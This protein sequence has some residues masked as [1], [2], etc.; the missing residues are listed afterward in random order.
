MSGHSRDHFGR[1]KD[2]GYS[3]EEMAGKPVDL[4]HHRHLVVYNPFAVFAAVVLL[5]GFMAIV[6]RA[7][8]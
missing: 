2:V 5:A 7:C 3:P 6:I 4:K 1:D 8:G